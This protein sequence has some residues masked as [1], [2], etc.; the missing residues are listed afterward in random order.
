[1]SVVHVHRD[2]KSLAFHMDVAGP[3]FPPFAGLVVM[4]SIDLYGDVPD[5]LVER[6]R[7]KAKL[8]GSGPVRVHRL[9]A[10][11]DRF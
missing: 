4:S 1:M 3:R 8:L 10:G 11:F 7:Q 6:L 9:A 5:D 2:A